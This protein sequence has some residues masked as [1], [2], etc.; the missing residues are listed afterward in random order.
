MRRAAMPPPSSLKP[1]VPSPCEFASPE[2][3]S[4]IRKSIN[5]FF[6]WLTGRS[7]PDRL[8]RRSAP[9]LCDSGI[10]GATA[11]VVNA[12]PAAEPARPPLAALIDAY[13]APTPASEKRGEYPAARRMAAIAQLRA[14]LD[15]HERALRAMALGSPDRE[16]SRMVGAIRDVQRAI[17]GLRAKIQQLETEERVA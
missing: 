7:G 11:S 17:A 3:R 5:R 9:S 13:A 8:G 6:R 1:S 15:Q 16:L 12:A 2:G 14:E 4:V 10:V